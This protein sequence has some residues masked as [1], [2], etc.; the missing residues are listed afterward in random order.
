MGA[1]DCN[2]ERRAL[3]ELINANKSCN[4]TADCGGASIG[5]GVSE[6]GCTGAVYTNRNVDPAEFQSLLERFRECLRLHENTLGCAICDRVE[7]PP[8]CRGGLCV[9]CTDCA[10]EIAA[11][12]DFKS[13]NDACEVDDDCITEIIG[14][15]V[16]EDDCTGAVYFSKDVDREE[17][18]LLRDE[19][20]A[21]TGGCGACRRIASPPA[22]VSG[23]CVIR[24]LR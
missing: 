23:H 17:L 3:R 16:T 19:Y 12:G 22:C 14:C 6:D 11:L 24:P 9:G 8:T 4:E 13:R 1:E 2:D 18:T 10:L 5:C 20:Y 7:T 15:E 21:C